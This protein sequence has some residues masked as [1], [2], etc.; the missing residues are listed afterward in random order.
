MSSWNGSSLV[1]ELSALLGDTSTAFQARVLGW[2]N[3]VIFDI[4]TRYD[5][6]YFKTKGKKK[7]TASQE[8]QPLEITAPSAPSVAIAAGGSLTVDTSYYV[9]ITFA[10]DNGVE[11][12]AGTASAVVTTS[13]GNLTINVTSI[14][15]STESLVTSRKVYL[16]KGSANYYLYSTIA[17]NSSTSTSITADTSST[18]EPPDYESIRKIS[19]GLF[20]ES[21]PQS[22]LR[23]RDIDQ[24]RLFAQGQFETNN[25][26]FFAPIGASSVI[27]YPLPTSGLEVSFYYYRNPKRLYNVSTSQPDLPVSLK[28]VLKAGVIAMGYEYRDRDGQETKRQ[29]YELLLSDA[30]TRLGKGHEIEYVIRDVYGNSEGFEVR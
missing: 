6:S 1:T 7:L 29:N 20:F 17:D 11:S 24:L 19:G 15:V 3:D 14:P 16:K 12:L 4:G 2:A 27:M 8:V 21:S 30:F 10:Q 23:A 22:Y 28:Q 26:E 9:L 25:P 18:I 13:T 5:W